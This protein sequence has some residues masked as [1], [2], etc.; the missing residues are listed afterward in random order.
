VKG[1]SPTRAEGGSDYREK[2][3]AFAW[4]RYLTPDRDRRQKLNR[5]EKSRDHLIRMG[6]PN[7]IQ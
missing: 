4:R 6:T 1:C 5:P 7:I 3:R 2:N